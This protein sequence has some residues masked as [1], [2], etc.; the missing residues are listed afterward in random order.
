MMFN[1]KQDGESHI[2]EINQ[3]TT[4]FGNVVVTFDKK[5]KLVIVKINFIDG[6]KETIR[7]KTKRSFNEFRGPIEDIIIGKVVDWEGIERT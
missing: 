3:H 5:E 7:K 2:T 1:W 4:Y 6:Q